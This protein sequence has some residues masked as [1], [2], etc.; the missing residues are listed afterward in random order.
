MPKFKVGDQVE[1]IGSLVPEYMRTGVIT[2]VVYHTDIRVT[3][4]QGQRINRQFPCFH[5]RHELESIHE[6]RL[7]HR[8]TAIA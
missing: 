1:R 5:V 3:F 8:S 4:S 2:R 7:L 6:E